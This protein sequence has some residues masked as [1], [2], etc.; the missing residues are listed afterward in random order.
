MTWCGKFASKQ[1]MKEAMLKT[2]SRRTDE[3]RIIGIEDATGEQMGLMGF[4]RLSIR[5][6]NP[7]GMQP[8]ELDGS[9]SVCN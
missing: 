4:Q 6:L 5:G 9:F 2:H 1:K 7:N 8:F 3:S